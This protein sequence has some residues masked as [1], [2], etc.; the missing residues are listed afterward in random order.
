MIVNGKTCHSYFRGCDGQ[1]TCDTDCQ[2]YCEGHDC[3]MWIGTCKQYL[4]VG[5][6]MSTDEKYQVKMVIDFGMNYLSITHNGYQWNSVKVAN[7]EEA[8][9]ICRE[10]IAFYGDDVLEVI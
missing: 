3:P 8:R 7:I 1:G 5:G 9:A 2:W 10:L 6:N 4:Q